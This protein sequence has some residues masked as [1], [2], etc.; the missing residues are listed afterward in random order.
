MGT[1]LVEVPHH[2]E[3]QVVKGKAFEHFRRAHTVVRFQDPHGNPDIFQLV[4]D[5]VA[6]IVH[7]VD[8]IQD[9]EQIG[10]APDDL[11]FTQT[12]AEYVATVE[13]KIEIN[14][15]FPDEI[16]TVIELLETQLI[17]VLVEVVIDTAAAVDVTGTYG[18]AKSNAVVLIMQV[19]A[20]NYHAVVGVLIDVET[21]ERCGRNTASV[22]NRALGNVLELNRPAG[23]T[24]VFVIIEVV[25]TVVSTAKRAVYGDIA[26]NAHVPYPFFPLELNGVPEFGE[27]HSVTCVGCVLIEAIDPGVLRGNSA[28]QRSQGECSGAGEYSAPQTQAFYFCLHGRS[29]FG[30]LWRLAPGQARDVAPA[31]YPSPS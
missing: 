26:E 12:G 31:T 18:Y 7:R 3:V 28:G 27:P 5:V 13:V 21:E 1:E 17:F 22:R 8:H 6:G 11:L 2:L 24:A 4:V 29:S 20:E 30:L 9:P 14:I 10:A 23:F 16:Q 19:L 25:D 15:E